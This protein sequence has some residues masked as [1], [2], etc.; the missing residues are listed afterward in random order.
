VI[1]TTESPLD[2]LDHH[3]RLRASGLEGRAA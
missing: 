1:A 3:R 2:A